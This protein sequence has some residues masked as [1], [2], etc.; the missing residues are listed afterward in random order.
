MRLLESSNIVAY[1]G[2]GE[3]QE[4]PRNKVVLWDEE[5]MAIVAE[6]LFPADVKDVRLRKDCLVV[7]LERKT[8]VYSLQTLR[9]FADFD[10]IDN[11]SALCAVSTGLDSLVI[12]VLTNIEGKPWITV[13]GYSD[14]ELGQEMN[15]N[16]SRQ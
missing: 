9:K 16:S 3:N 13:H 5:K 8:V 1:V 15:W 2:T 14:P 11:P 7:I 4:L 12:A 10:S 6:L